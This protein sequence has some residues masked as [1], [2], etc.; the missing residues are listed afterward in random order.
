MMQSIRTG[1]K[2][3]IREINQAIVLDAVRAGR[4]LSRTDIAR[5]TGLGLPTVSGITAELIDAGLLVEGG[6]GKSA[7]GRRPVM[8]SLNASAGYVVG[9]KVT[10]VEVISVLTDLDANVVD[11]HVEVLRDQSVDD[12]V[13]AVARCVVRLTP[14]AGGRPVHGVG[15]G[16]A[17][18]IDR[19]RGIVRH[20]TYSTWPTVDLGS[21]LEAR[22]ALPVVVDN[23]VNALVAAEQ[24]FGVGR[25]VA[26]FVAVSVGRG[27]GL[28]MVLDG[29]LYRG[30]HGGAGELG[31]TKVDPDGPTCPCGQ[32]GC[33][34]AV[35]GEPAI[36]RR[37]SEAS[38]RRLTITDVLE[39]AAR[40][41][42]TAVGALRDAGH[43]L[44][45]AIGNLVNILNPRLVVLAGEG[46][47][48]SPFLLDSL[49]QALHDTTFDGLLD[50]LELVVEPW[51]DEA[52]ARGAAS[53]VLGELFQPALRPN[54][55]GRPSLTARPSPSA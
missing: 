35:A 42:A 6:T 11:R 13:G 28:G 54:E 7:G 49:Q 27:I 46:T 5:Q 17:G 14:S 22:L 4:S 36:A 52:W 33:L 10:E 32:R 18:V 47:R 30:A 2:H 43:R 9:V 55:S 31:H 38:G 40:D 19:N 34:E 20:A 45:V 23:D 3:L 29:R 41:D 48:A 51:D 8:L 1:S 24:W 26:D 44:G 50:E 15:V 12:V 39:L 53:L 37:V 25:D 16:L 21:V